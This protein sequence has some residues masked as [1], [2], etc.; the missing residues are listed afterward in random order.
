MR[1][2]TRLGLAVLA[3]AAVAAPARAQK[4]ADTL[5]VTWRDAIPNV[6]PYYNSL[7][8]GLVLAHQ[9]WDGL[10]YRDP[11]TFQIKP[12]LAASWRYVDPTTIE[13]ALRRDVTFQNGDKFSADDVVYTVNTIL[14]DKQVSV[15]SNYS[16][17]AGA[18]KV[19]DYTVRIRLKRVFPAALEYFSMT[20]PI[21]P[22]TYRERIG[23]DAYAH[24]PI[25]AG[26]YRIAKVDGTTEIDLERYDGY[27]AGSPKG[28]PAI[29]KLVIHEVADATTEL[30]E[31]LG[32]RAD[33][34]WNFISDN[35]DNIN[36]VPTLQAMRAESMRVGYLQFDAA[37]R[38]GADNPMT[39]Q[40]VRQAIAMAIDRVS[41]AKNLMQGGS[42]VPDAP[43]FPTQF[44]CDENA[45]IHYDYDPAKAKALLAEAGYPN[46]FDADI[47]TYVLPQIGGA[48]QN[49][50]KA[51]GINAHLTQ[52][53]AGAVIQ[54]VLEGKAQSNLGSWGSYS[55]NDVSAF[56]PF[57]FTGSDTDYSRD[58]ELARL[59][60]DG[61]ATTD[62][63]QR[64]RDYDQAIKLV[65]EK[66]YFL[67]LHTYVVNYG[68]SR[69]LNFKPYPDEMPRFFLSSWK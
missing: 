66:M 38:T 41:I 51:V 19:D 34:I 40:K 7:R 12:L 8:T 33:W 24:A 16:F 23:A 44:G 6:D 49:Y 63:D 21:W 67:P 11:D 1:G 53:Q 18:D 27:Y 47:L 54:R 59:V 52:M 14:T 3:M 26:P 57:F 29:G 25:G 28:R 5:R 60:N 13:F 37:G 65:T 46:G 15:P 61:G 17:I 9:A 43:C 32:G 55:I 35:F 22:K 10:V 45:A 62:P 36:R 50:L 2:A 20:L 68:I 42:R 31:L 58:P 48:V 64:R 4:S 39:K 30:N 69:A 56:M